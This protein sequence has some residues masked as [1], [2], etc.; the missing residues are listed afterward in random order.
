MLSS[1]A[2]NARNSGFFRRQV[3]EPLLAHRRHHLA[4]RVDAVHLEAVL[5]GI[6]EDVAVVVPMVAPVPVPARLRHEL[7]LGDRSAVPQL[8]RRLLRVGIHLEANQHLASAPVQFPDHLQLHAVEGDVGV[9]LTDEQHAHVVERGRELTRSQRLA[10]RRVGDA[11]EDHGGLA[12]APGGVADLEFPGRLL[13][14]PRRGD[15]EGDGDDER[16]GRGT[17]H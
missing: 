4:R 11:V 12:V 14:Q 7:V 1:P 3:L 8:E 5:P 10:G 15:S 17:H 6:Q 13:R 16:Q 9:A 2:K